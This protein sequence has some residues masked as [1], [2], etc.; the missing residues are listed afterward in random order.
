VS[1]FVLVYMYKQLPEET[2][3]GYSNAL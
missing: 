2:C 3:R 1:S